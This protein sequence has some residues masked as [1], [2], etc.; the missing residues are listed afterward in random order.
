MAHVN[1]MGEGSLPSITELFSLSNKTAICTGATGGLGLSMAIALAEAGA[2]IV[3]IQLKG[4]PRADLLK[5]GVAACGRKLQVFETDVA[6]SPTLRKCFQEIWAAGVV[7]DILLNCAGINRRSQ[8]ENF[9]DE[10]IDAVGFGILVSSNASWDLTAD[11]CI[12]II[13]FCDKPEGNIRRC[14]RGGQEA[15][16]AEE[17]GQGELS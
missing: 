16:R 4:D 7:P 10:D 15:V 6:D 9:T 1:Q 8:V 13:D 12:V 2:D 5:E 11:I 14:T 3:S 17:T